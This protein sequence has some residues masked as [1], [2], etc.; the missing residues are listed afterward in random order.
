MARWSFEQYKEYMA[1]RLQI[2]EAKHA[3]EGP[4]SDLQGKILKWAK[5]H[6][7]PCQCFR[8]SKK[9]YGFLVPGWPD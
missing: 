1:N 7:Y 2:D 4:E 9:A 8:K 5:T 3:D 6:G